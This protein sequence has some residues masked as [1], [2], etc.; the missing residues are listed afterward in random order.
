VDPTVYSGGFSLCL[1]QVL[2]SLTGICAGA[3]AKSREQLPLDASKIKALKESLF[4][5][6]G[7]DGIPPSEVLNEV[8]EVISFQDVSVLKNE[9]SLL[10]ALSKM[11]EIRNE[12]LP[13][14]GAKD[15]HY[16]MKSVEVREIALVSELFV[17][18]SLMRKESRA[19]HFRADY[20]GR[21]NENW[22]CWIIARQEGNNIKW[23]KKPVPIEKYKIK[24]TKYYSDNFNYPDVMGLLA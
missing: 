17:Q 2:G 12:L 6:I 5:P 7:K 4:E 11:E 19:G 23:D 13:R 22:L 10:K 8:R 1:C 9:K 18:A 20:P 3:F 16:L 15:P 14:M 24:P 21:D